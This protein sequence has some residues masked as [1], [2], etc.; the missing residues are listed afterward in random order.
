MSEPIADVIDHLTGI[1][2]DSRLDAIRRHRP[3]ARENAQKSYLA[4]FEPRDAGTLALRE[5]FA[6]ATFVAGLHGA[7]DIAA[8][9]RD[10]LLHHSAAPEFADLIDREAV[11]GTAQ[12]PYGHYP[13]GP[14]VR[15][16]KNG[17]HYRVLP[18]HQALLG[19]RLAAA[20]EHAHLLVFHPRDAKAASLHALLDV[21]F[22]ENDIVTLSQL[23]SFLSFQIRV[24]AGLRALRAA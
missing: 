23:V 2:A 5:R 9:Y 17:P 15:E 11:R 20:L 10:G 1:A 21:K 22:S 24:V 12:G 3:E 8:F 18:T 19:A 4:L 14:L 6:V 16:N 7:D 13:S